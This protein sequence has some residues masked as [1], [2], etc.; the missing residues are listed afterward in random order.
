MCV[1][2]SFVKVLILLIILSFSEIC[3]TQ[4]LES[5]SPST[6]ATYIVHLKKPHDTDFSELQDLQSW[7]QSFLPTETETVNPN[8]YLAIQ[9]GILE[10]ASPGNLGPFNGTVQ[11]AGPWILTVGAS[12]I[13]RSFKAPLGLLNPTTLPPLVYPTT[14]NHTL[15]EFCNQRTLAN[16]RDMVKGKVVLCQ[17]RGGEAGIARGAE[18]KKYGGVAMILMN[19]ELDGYTIS[20]ETHQWLQIKAYINSTS[21]PTATILYKGTQTGNSSAPIVLS[22]SSRGP[23]AAIPGILKPDIIGPGGNILGAWPSDSS[24]SVSSAALLK[25]SHPD[26]S[27]AAIKSAMMTTADVLD[28]EDKPILDYNYAP[29]ELFA[30]GAGHVNPSKANDPGLVYDIQPDDYIP[31]LCGF[32]YKDKEIKS[33]PES[34]LNYPS[35]SITFGSSPQVVTRTVTNVGSASSNY[36]VKG[37][38]SRGSK[39]SI[40]VK[41]EEIVFT[42]LKQTATYKVTFSLD[43]EGYSQSAGHKLFARGSLQ[44]ISAEHGVSSPI[45][46][47]FKNDDRMLLLTVSSLKP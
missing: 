19:E 44:W 12:T 43:D 47:A 26:W 34:Q 8:P 27:P 36:T 28:H 33:I 16:V 23:Y 2:L 25:S 22:F 39:H 41:P 1:L 38:F 5:P 40:Q 24:F 4:V 35:F 18:V 6:L 11:N 45:S 3:S 20:A 42:K 31:Y 17:G 13:D 9:K 37:C 46:V 21:T 15:S 29:A 10:S 7:H 32:K 14:S 30:T